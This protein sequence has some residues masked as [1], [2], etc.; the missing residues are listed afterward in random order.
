MK[1][2]VVSALLFLIGFL[3]MLEVCFRLASYHELDTESSRNNSSYTPYSPIIPHSYLGYYQLPGSYK[4]TLN[5]FLSYTCTHGL[6]SLRITSLDSSAKTKCD[7][8]V[9]GCSFTYGQG[10]D[11]TATFAWILQKEL[12]GERV[13][14]FGVIGFGTVQT[15]LQLRQ[16]EIQHLVPKTVIINYASFHNE[17]NTLPRWW[18]KKLIPARN[19][20]PDSL[21]MQVAFCS[22]YINSNSTLSIKRTLIGSIYS[23]PFLMRKSALVNCVDDFVNVLTKML[24]NKQDVSLR[25]IE[26]INSICK[27]NGSR[28]L[29]AGIYNDEGTQQMLSCCALQHIDTV[30]IAVDLNRKEFNNQPYDSHP[31]A[32]AHR[33]YAERLYNKL[34]CLFGRSTR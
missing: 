6:D 26:E 4:H 28:L 22:A 14:N 18:R 29:V 31:N 9:F 5:R 17:R 32:K 2:R 30:T 25:I 7:I 12:V 24:I 11:D 15:L 21:L 16:L 20:L 3:I 10:V 1:R 8:G 27:K 19:V 33:I 13:C 23:E 34:I